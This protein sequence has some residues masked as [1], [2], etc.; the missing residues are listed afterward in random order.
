MRILIK[1]GRI[2]DPGQSEEAADLLVEDGIIREVRA[3]A[4]VTD[5]DEP[6]ADRVIDVRGYLVM[7][8]LIDTHVHLREPGQEYKETIA[9]GCRAAAWGGIT[10]V[11]CMP[12]TDPVN[13][14]AGVTEFIRKKA[15]EAG[16]ARV[17][18]AA[19]ISRG[20]QGNDLSE[21]GELKAAGAVAVTDDGMPVMD[22][23][24]MRRALEYARG[25][26]MTVMTHSE[27]LALSGSGVMNEGLVSTRLGLSGIPNCSE[28]VMVTRDIALCALTRS[29]L[30]IAHVSTRESVEAIR[31]AKEQGLPV[32]A[33]TAPHYFTLT[34]EDVGEYDTHAKMNPP[35]RSREDQ[36]AIRQGLADG[37]IDAIATDH[38][39]HSAIEK[40]VEF[41]QAA[42]GII[43]L[44]TS[45]PLSL[46]LVRE[47]VLTLSQLVERMS[48]APAG[49][50]G[51]ERGIRP[52]KPADITVID[53]DT[54]Y[55]VDA[56]NFQSLSR[57]CPFDGW[58]VQG[59]AVLTMVAGNVVYEYSQTIRQA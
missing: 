55:R 18:P 58:E 21:F 27:D 11:C 12:N 49:I 50:L 2:I 9:S 4:A 41:D 54:A 28:S 56:R 37:T 17:Y 44:E 33:E 8:G 14:N 3:A 10:A 34:D 16:M 19:A 31:R 22:A 29:K 53:P 46:G 57:N 6:D 15:E 20:L 26:G 45:L 23:Q 52:G 42:N 40:D 1:G 32:T 35:L 5:T 47:G 39:P 51:L 13:D 36:E 43:G 7:P 25:F 38:A 59:R 30:H 24:L 48:L